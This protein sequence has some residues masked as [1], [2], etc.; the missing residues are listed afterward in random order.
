[1]LFSIN[2]QLGSGKSAVCGLLEEKHNFLVFSTG[3]IHRELAKEQGMTSVLFN[4]LIKNDASVDAI[5]DKA[6]ISFAEAN[7]GK[8]IIFDS[9]LAW[10]FIENTFKIFLIVAPSIAANRVFKTR[11]VEEKYE[12]K[13]DALAELMYRRQLENERFIRTYG[14][15]CNDY[16]N[17]DVIID[18]SLLS[19]E[20]VVQFIME[21]YT[22]K[23]QNIEYDSVL[24]S[25]INLYPTKGINSLD[26]DRVSF[27]VDKFQKNEEVE[28]ISLL[29]YKNE[30]FIYD[31]HH[32]VIAANQV[33]K[34]VMPGWIEFQ[35]NERMP[36]GVLPEQYISL[37]RSDLNGWEGACGFTFEFYPSIFFFFFKASLEPV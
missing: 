29:R 13:E 1:M 25:P 10:H 28:P 34:M 20:Q 33:K 2:G 3:K 30:L 7:K 22:K 37:S 35:E 32:R 6:C 18:A 27:Y 16:R 9:R 4:E 26:M 8:E 21:T 12:S 5:V 31:G 14:V 23:L 17:Y 15:D 24:C 11:I 19:V 36:T